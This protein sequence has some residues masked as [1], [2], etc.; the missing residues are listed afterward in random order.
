MF[1]IHKALKVKSEEA[2]EKDVRELVKKVL[3]ISM[4]LFM[5]NSNKQELQALT[6]NLI[7]TARKSKKETPSQLSVDISS[8]RLI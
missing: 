1:K 3:P 7:E 5:A 6:S 2:K 4:T 8:R